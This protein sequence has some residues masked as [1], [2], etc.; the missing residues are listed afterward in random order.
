[1]PDAPG[2]RP[3]RDEGQHR[4]NAPRD[5][6]WKA[7]LDPEILARTPPGTETLERDGEQ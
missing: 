4:F 7:L 5:L 3:S 6:V 2:G 1:L